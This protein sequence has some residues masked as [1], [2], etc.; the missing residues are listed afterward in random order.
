MPIMEPTL[1]GHMWLHESVLQCLPSAVDFG[2]GQPPRQTSVLRLYHMLVFL[3]F[4]PAEDADW[5][6]L[7][8][9]SSLS[10]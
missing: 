7:G 9:G 4:T 2:D 3:V 6:F 5:L 8:I 1:D 10:L